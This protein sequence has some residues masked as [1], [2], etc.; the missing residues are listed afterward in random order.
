M[1]VVDWF[2]T[3]MKRVH[4]DVPGNSNQQYSIIGADHRHLTLRQAV[5]FNGEEGARGGG[6]GGGREGRG[7][8]CAS[9]R[10]LSHGGEVEPA[11]QRLAEVRTHI[12]ICGS[13]GLPVFCRGVHDEALEAH[14]QDALVICFVIKLP[15]A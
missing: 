3:C 4:L 14:S 6:G 15:Q 5:W 2:G 1:A 13:R 11:Q 9:L 12:H 10:K 8:G 7:L